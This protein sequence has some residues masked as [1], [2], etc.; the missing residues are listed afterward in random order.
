MPTALN[1]STRELVSR[2]LDVFPFE[3]AAL[4]RLWAQLLAGADDCFSRSNL[5]G[6]VTT[7][8]AV[9]SP[10]RDKVLVI[11]HR[12]LQNW[13]PPGGH[14]EGTGTLW[15]SAMREVA[16]ETGLT[17]IELHPWCQTHGVPFDIDTHVVPARPA[18]GEGSHL[19]HDFR[20][21]AVARSESGLTPQL[22]EV[23]GARWAPL[24]EFAL[25]DDRRL[26][27]L[28]RKLSTLL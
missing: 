11:H 20:Y 24:T 27:T 22:E 8:A 28:A 18:K 10:G 23:L 17:D 14:Y 12:F 16:E 26:Q 15:E 5:T 7:S 1:M 4:S 6:H 3:T 21:L 9:L 25:N 19:H 13:L 2:Y